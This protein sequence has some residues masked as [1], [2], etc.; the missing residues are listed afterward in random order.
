MSLL[1]QINPA[2]ENRLREKAGRKGVGINQFISRFLEEAFGNEIPNQLSVSEREATLLQQVNLNI[3][4]EKWTSYLKLK[5][6][7]QKKTLS[8]TELT[9]LIGL[10]NEI[11]SANAVRITVLAELAQLRNIPIRVLMEQLGLTHHHE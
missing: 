6:K 3:S 11:E 1:I 10:N 5:E 4:P 7:R 2:L 9:E 8:D